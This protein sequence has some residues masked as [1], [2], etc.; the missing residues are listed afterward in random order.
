MYCLGWFSNA[1]RMS[2]S[3]LTSVNV[4]YSLAREDGGVVGDF[5]QHPAHPLQSVDW[6]QR[7]ACLT[8]YVNHLHC[9]RY[10]KREEILNNMP[11]QDIIEPPGSNR[12]QV[13][14]FNWV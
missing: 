1:S 11:Q 14:V 12:S 2:M 10:K 8:H 4:E 3:N 7:N 5:S 13:V 6:I 9:R